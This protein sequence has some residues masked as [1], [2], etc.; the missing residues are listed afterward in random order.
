VT[1][2]TL[3][4]TAGLRKRRY[5]GHPSVRTPPEDPGGLLVLRGNLF[6][7]AIMKTSVIGSDFRH[8]YLER[9]GARGVFEGR[10]IVFDGS[11]DYHARIND[12]ALHI[13]ATAYS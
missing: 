10:A 9:P 4:E 7:Y 2:R 13:D 6:D 8:R 11:E 12:P 5:R 3:A 1:G